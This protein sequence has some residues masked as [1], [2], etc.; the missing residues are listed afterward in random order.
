MRSQYDPSK[1]RELVIY[2]AA[3]SR[4]DRHFGSK[5]LAKILYYS[6]FIAYG[7]LGAPITGAVYQKFPHG[8]F[9]K[10]LYDVQQALIEEEAVRIEQVTRYIYRQNRL[11]PLRDPDLT[12]FSAPEIALVERIIDELQPYNGKDV[13]E[14]SHD[15]PGWKAAAAYGEI[16]YFAA[17]L[18][19]EVPTAEDVTW[20]QS[21]PQQP[22]FEVAR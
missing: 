19:P 6:D 21:L 5:K 12:L 9:P 22:G 13:E 8:P 16:P 17:Y 11:V 2:I 10:P 20:V 3:K 18:S 14:M 1:F 4:D 15:E 7:E